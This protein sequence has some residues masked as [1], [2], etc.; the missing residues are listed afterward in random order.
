MEKCHFESFQVFPCLAYV[1]SVSV[2]FRSKEQGKRVKMTKVKEFGGGGKKGRKRLQTKP[3]FWKPLTW[4]VMPEFAHW[5]LTVSSAVK[6][7]Q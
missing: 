4:P 5:H 3:E 7:G 2:R 1:A 6:I